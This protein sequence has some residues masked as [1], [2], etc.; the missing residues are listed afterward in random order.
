MSR[1][2]HMTCPN[3]Q[4]DSIDSH[5]SFTRESLSRRLEGTGT[6]RKYESWYRFQCEDC[7]HTFASRDR[8]VSRVFDENGEELPEMRAVH[9]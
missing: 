5:G 3:C 8:V 4:S 7:G 2:D 9:G 1:Q 6:R